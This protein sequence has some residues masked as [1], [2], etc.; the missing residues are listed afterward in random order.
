MPRDADC[1]E[2]WLRP[3]RQAQGGAAR[4]EQ[5]AVG[6]VTFG[7]IELHHV[8]VDS[9]DLPG[10]QEVTLGQRAGAVLPP[11]AQKAS[12]GPAQSVT[13]WESH[14]P[15]SGPWTITSLCPSTSA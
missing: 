12:M 9:G 3:S 7:D 11:A 10:E 6:G 1:C 13:Y 15:W 8:T 4:H 2:R 5:R 14:A